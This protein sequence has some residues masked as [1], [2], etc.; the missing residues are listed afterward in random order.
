MIV[1]LTGIAFLLEGGALGYQGI[2]GFIGIN[3]TQVIYTACSSSVNT[4]LS[5]SNIF[6]IVALACAAVALITL[7]L[8][9]ILILMGMCKWN[10]SESKYV[11]SG[12]QNNE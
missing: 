8:M 1:V 11:E 6:F 2:S 4:I 10:S 3:K 12:P 7:A 5:N 9:F